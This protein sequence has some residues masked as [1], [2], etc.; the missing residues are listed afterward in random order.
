MLEGAVKN[1]VP[2]R[3]VPEPHDNTI[4]DLISNGTFRIPNAETTSA[5]GWKSDGEQWKA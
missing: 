1:P 2:M 5:G 3:S 4:L